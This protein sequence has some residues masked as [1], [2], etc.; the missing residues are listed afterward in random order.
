MLIKADPPLRDGSAPI[1][2][3]PGGTGTGNT[4]KEKLKNCTNK[5]KEKK[6]SHQHSEKWTLYMKLKAE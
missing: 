5:K 3:Y 6:L 1:E 4:L 2:T